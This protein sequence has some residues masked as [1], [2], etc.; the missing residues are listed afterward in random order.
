MDELRGQADGAAV[1]FEYVFMSTLSEEFSDYVSEAYSFQ[2]TE[3]CS[4][5]IIN[6]GK[7]R[8]HSILLQA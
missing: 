6:E 2:P 8:P 5:V 4:D 1:P 3:S 7:E